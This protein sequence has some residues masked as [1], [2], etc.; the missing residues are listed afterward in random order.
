M[1]TGL[2]A[3]LGGVAAVLLAAVCVLLGVVVSGRRRTQRELAAARADVETLR[4]RLEQLEAAG[5]AASAPPV[6]PRAEYLITTVGSELDD[7]PPRVPNR[8]V[9]SATLGEPL[10]KV[11]SFAYGVRR[12]L[13]AE[14]RNRIAFEIRREIR[15]A[16]KQRRR[17]ARRADRTDRTER[18][19]RAD[20]AAA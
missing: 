8:M 18:A 4:A 11:V 3:A 6:V 19:D 2:L 1:E 9:L 7:D 15:R 17:N 13:S 12:A 16:R 14:S 10:V 5:G 20:R